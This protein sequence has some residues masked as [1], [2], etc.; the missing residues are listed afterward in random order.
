MNVLIISVSPRQESV[1]TNLDDQ[2]DQDDFGRRNAHVPVKSIS[3]PQGKSPTF[4]Q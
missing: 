3:K 1:Q 2:N 4:S